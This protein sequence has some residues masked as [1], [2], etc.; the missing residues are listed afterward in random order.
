MDNI[1][2]PRESKI[3]DLIL[4]KKVKNRTCVDLQFLANR[5]RKHIVNM[6]YLAGSGHPGGALGLADVFC[7]LYFFVMRYN[8]K[9]QF[10]DNKNDFLFMSNGH[11]CAVRYAAMA[12]AGFF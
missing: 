3:K 12:I 10:L 11:T 6:T 4:L 7:I 9:N 8:V 1:F 2:I 5:M